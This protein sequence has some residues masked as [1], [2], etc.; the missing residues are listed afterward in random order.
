MFE[1]SVICH[2]KRLS[3]ARGRGIAVNQCSS[4]SCIS[5]DNWLALY[6]KYHAIGGMAT[7]SATKIKKLLAGHISPGKLN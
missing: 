5:P 2:H 1:T 7:D 4:L 3:T 6:L